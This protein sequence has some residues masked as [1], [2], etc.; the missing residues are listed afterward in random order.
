MSYVDI[1]KEVGISRIAVKSRIDALEEKQI[2]EQYTII[3]NPDFEMNGQ[4]FYQ[5][6]MNVNISIENIRRKNA[7][8][9]ALQRLE[10]M[11]IRDGLTNLYNRFGFERYSKE[12]Y[13]KCK[14][15]KRAMLILFADLNRLK[16]INDDFGHENGDI[17][18]KTIA[19]VLIESKMDEDVCTRFGGD[20]FILMGYD[21]TA[22]KAEELIKKVDEGLQSANTHNNYPYSIS[23]SMG[24]YIIE[25][26]SEISLKDAI[27]M[28]DH[29]MY[30]AKKQY[31]EQLK[32]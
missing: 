24:Y 19:K 9:D 20:E 25:S 1:A 31:M 10:E 32:K 18:I 13:R 22:S 28:A 29:H 26:G 12:I 27:D 7:M 30:Q 15:E 5:W 4:S 11:Y 6:L 14:T 16:H 2:I 8:N 3:V 21:Y 17:A 23:A